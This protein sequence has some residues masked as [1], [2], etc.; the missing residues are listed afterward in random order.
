MEAETGREKGH[1]VVGKVMLQECWE[2]SAALRKQ[3]SEA[4][5]N[6]NESTRGHVAN[7]TGKNS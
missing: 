5:E 4:E 6:S 3:M 2:E 7:V 1:Q